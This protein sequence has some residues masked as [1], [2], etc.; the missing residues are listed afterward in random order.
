[1]A[2]RPRSK[3]G[4]GRHF[5]RSSKLAAELV[6][7]AR[8]QRGDLVLDLGAGGGVLTSALSRAGARVVPIEIDQQL[9]HDLRRR[10]PQTIEGD[11]L[12]VPLPHEEFKVVANLPFDGATAILR[13]LL[14]PRVPLE[15]AEHAARDVLER[16]V[17]ALRRTQ[18]APFR[19]RAAAG[20]GCGTAATPPPRRAARAVAGAASLCGVPRPRFPRGSAC[21]ALLR[22]P[23]AARVGARLRPP[24]TGTRPRLAPVGGTV[25]AHR[26]AKRLEFPATEPL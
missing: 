20:G 17:R 2:V 1:V 13:R 19:L 14:D 23:Q 5:L 16:L 26:P 6:R 25:R 7:G 9:A 3:R 22:D 12:R 24:G 11:A 4:G 18:A 15:T 8:V 10:F 21:R